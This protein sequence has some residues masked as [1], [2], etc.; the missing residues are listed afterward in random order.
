MT[1]CHLC[2]G[3]GHRCWT[4]GEADGHCDCCDPN[5]G[6]CDWCKGTGEEPEEASTEQIHVIPIG[7]LREHVLDAM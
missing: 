4:C 7:D 1:K 2:F 3:D 5:Q 6:E